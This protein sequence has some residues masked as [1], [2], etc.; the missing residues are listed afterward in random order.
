MC[1]INGKRC[2]KHDLI[3]GAEA[4]E[5]RK[6]IEKFM[7]KIDD[8]YAQDVPRCEVLEDLQKLLDETDARDSLAYCESAYSKTQ[9]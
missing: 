6:G 4:E 9:R 1:S 7:E 2:P 3:H 5:L 8:D